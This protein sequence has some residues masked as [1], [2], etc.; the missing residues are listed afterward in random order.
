M[1]KFIGIEVFE[2]IALY[3]DLKVYRTD[4]V[5]S[6]DQIIDT[7]EALDLLSKF[8]DQLWAKVEESEIE[9]VENDETGNICEQC[10]MT[11][12]PHLANDQI[13][14]IHTVRNELLEYVNDPTIKLDP[15]SIL[16]AEMLLGNYE[17]FHTH[18]EK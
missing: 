10:G 13:A 16:Y 15:D 8:P 1:K 7:F 5:T 3:S 4:P 11:Y 18:A 2:A 12:I 9:K 17:L 6:K 14:K